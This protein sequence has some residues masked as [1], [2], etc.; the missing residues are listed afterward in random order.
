LEEISNSSGSE[1][2]QETDKS[3]FYYFPDKI[4][5]WLGKKLMYKSMVF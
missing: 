3:Q 2:P 5:G 4:L 1:E